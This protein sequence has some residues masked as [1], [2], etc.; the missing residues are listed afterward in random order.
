MELFH[1]EAAKSEADEKKEGNQAYVVKKIPRGLPIVWKIL[2]VFT[3]S[4]MMSQVAVTRG[5]QALEPVTIESG[6][7][8]RIPEVQEQAMQYIKETEPDFIV[9]AWPCG[10]WSQIQNINQRTD[11]QR[12]ALRQKR[13]LSRRTFLSGTN[14]VIWKMAR[15]PWDGGP[16][17]NQFH[18]FHSYTSYSWYSFGI[19]PSK[20][21]Q[22]GGLNSS[23]QYRIKL[24]AWDSHSH[25]TPQSH[26]HS[27]IMSFGVPGLTLD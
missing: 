24:Q 27:R 15:Y 17:N 6:W 13:A 23:L 25:T 9:L 10:P 14:P 11:L 18:S 20:R 2:E 8:L 1:P 7:D 4:C 21:L 22:H 3:W 5:W 16:L 12:R 26:S 19:S